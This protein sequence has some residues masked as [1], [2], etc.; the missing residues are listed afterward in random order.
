[1]AGVGLHTREVGLD[2]MVRR[3]K[4]H[5]ADAAAAA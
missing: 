1:M 4:R 2:A 3:L 5:A